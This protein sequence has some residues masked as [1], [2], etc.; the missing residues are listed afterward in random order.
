MSEPTKRGRRKS[1][2]KMSQASKTAAV[3]EEDIT[4]AFNY[5]TNMLEKTRPVL[6]DKRR[7]CIG[8][9]IH[10]YGLERVQNAIE[11]CT[12]SDFHMGRN[13]ANKKYDDVSLI[14]RDAEHIERFLDLYDKREKGTDW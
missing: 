12:F 13:R 8:A 3:A 4:S 14:L 11:G 7:Q 5:W 2:H 9:A 6:D 10:D 1:A